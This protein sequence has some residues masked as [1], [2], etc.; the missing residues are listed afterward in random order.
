MRVGVADVA[1][2][3]HMPAHRLV[4]PRLGRT[5][6]DRGLLAFP[7]RIRFAHVAGQPVRIGN[8]HGYERRL[9]ARHASQQPQ[10][11]VIVL[12]QRHHPDVDGRMSARQRARVAQVAGHDPMRRIVVRP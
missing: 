12:A 6:H 7:D 10:G 4:S 8:G 5:A 1:D 3:P 11:R 9:R 2:D